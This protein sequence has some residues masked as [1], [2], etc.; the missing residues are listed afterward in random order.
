MPDT[1]DQLILKPELT[2]EIELYVLDMTNIP[3]V[4]QIYRYVNMTDATGAGSVIFGGD[5]YTTY[6]IKLTG[7]QRQTTGA[8]ARPS[9]S[10]S[11]IN[12]LFGSLSFLYEDLVGSKVTYIK[13]FAEFLGGAGAISAPPIR[14]TIGSKTNHT[15]ESITWEL[16]S[17]LDKEGGKLP[18][19]QMLK[20]DFPGL[21]INKQV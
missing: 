2:A 16:R 4:N 17:P 9:I 7:I 20:R 13:T 10:I 11:N 19:R 12:K 8:L 6:P 14:F 21:G 1:L 18:G 15:T 5:T 3:E